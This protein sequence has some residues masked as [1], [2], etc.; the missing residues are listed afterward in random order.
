MFAIFAEQFFHSRVPILS[1]E[2]TIPP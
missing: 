1:A 2:K